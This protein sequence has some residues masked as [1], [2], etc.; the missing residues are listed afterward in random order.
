MNQSK[1]PEAA[2]GTA[3]LSSTQQASIRAPVGF[4]ALCLSH[5]HLSSLSS[6]Q[7]MIQNRALGYVS[8]AA[9]LT[10]YQLGFPHRGCAVPIRDVFLAWLREGGNSLIS[11]Y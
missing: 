2:A 3:F 10:A 8:I 4:L 11:S 7:F 9:D 6:P 5:S 1:I